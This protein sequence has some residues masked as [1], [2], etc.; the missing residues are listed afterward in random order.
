M[1]AMLRTGVVLAAVLGFGAGVAWGQESAAKAVG[2]EE[3]LAS[4]GRAWREKC[5][6]PGVTISAIGG[7]GVAV[8]AS[9]GVS[10]LATRAPMKPE[11]RMFSGSIG[12]TYFAAV[13]LQLAGEGK[14]KLDDRISE[15]V[16]KE[17]WFPGL[18][19]AEALTLRVLMNHT[20]GIPEHV[21]T[22]EFLAVLKAE[23]M[24]RW[25]FGDLLQKFA[26]GKTP[27]FEVG[28]GWSYAD[29]NYIV[30]GMVVEKATG[31]GMYEL[32]R[33]RVLSPLKLV[34]TVPSDGPVI[35][36]LIPGYE[37]PRKM[38]TDS[39]EFVVDGKCVLNPQ[40]EWCGGG[41]VS[42]SAD[43]AKWG[44]ALW[45]GDVISAEM[46]AEMLKGVEEKMTGPKDAYGLGVIIWE[47]PVGRAFGHTGMFP[48][49]VSQV[50]HFE[51]ANV[52]VAMQCNS[53]DLPKMR[54][55]RGVVLE[56]VREVTK[57]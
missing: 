53:M 14:V 36:R 37:G 45:S 6:A 47:S 52:T 46:K 3:A 50:F 28:K 9:A 2:R 21:E 38:F 10:R 27:L 5:G 43:L 25:D 49:Y 40:F 23:P 17:A 22:Q 42:T 35:P 56:V 20:S 57:E 31:K 34:D 39:E 1:K 48:G 8:N 11:D 7:D 29:T 32:V 55:M 54:G 41:F 44:R 16:G 12:K 24:K 51:K 26:C 13:I 19:N 33:E 30:A 15:V 18:P 4:I